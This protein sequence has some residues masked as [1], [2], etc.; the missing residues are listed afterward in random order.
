MSSVSCIKPRL[1]PL[2]VVYFQALLPRFPLSTNDLHYYRNK[3][4]GYEGECYFDNLLLQN[5]LTQG[6]LVPDLNFER[7]NTSCQIDTLLIS[8][9]KIY[10][11]E[12]KNFEGEHYIKGDSWCLRTSNKTITNPVHQMQ[13]AETLLRQLLKPLR[14]DI[15]IES[16]VVF[17]NPAFTLYH[18]PFDLPVILPTQ[19]N[20][21]LKTLSH[22][23]SALYNSHRK[24]AEF[25]LDNHV[26]DPESRRKVKYDYED[27]KKGAV[28]SKCN[29][30]DVKIGIYK[31]LCTRCGLIEEND[32][33]LLKAIKAFTLLVPEKRVTINNI[34]EWCNSAHSAKTIRR[35]LKNNYK[36]VKQG[37]YSYYV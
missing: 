20:R 4:K 5:F 18:A 2:E 1:T 28:C 16:Y 34:N 17:V 10:L 27:L 36:L 14:L 29:S 25:L 23:T 32:E 9:Q 19:L 11:F 21:F 15:S 8:Q 37:K 6:Y 22:Q 13:R 30:F 33:N 26:D 24:L 35:V 3:V 12:V 31:T 7:N